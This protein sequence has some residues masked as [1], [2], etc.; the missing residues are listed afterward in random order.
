MTK[1]HERTD[2]FAVCQNSKSIKKHKHLLAKLLLP[3]AG[4][5]SLVWFLIRVIPKPSRALYPCQRVAA[6]LASGFVA[7]LIGLLSSIAFIRKARRYRS[8]LSFLTAGLCFAAAVGSIWWS[9]SMTGK[10]VSA[11]TF[12]P[13][14][15]PNSPIGTAR[16][17]YPGRV[18]WVHDANATSW[19][20]STG[21]WSD[22]TN[23]D[24]AVVNTMLSKA[25]RW[26]TGETSD[27]NSWQEI[28][29][30]FNERHGKGRVGYQSG[31]KIAIKINMAVCADNHANPANAAYNSPQF[32]EALLKQL[33]N[34][35]GVRP[36]DITVYDA[37][38]YIPS[39]I[40]DR[41]STGQLAG[42]KFVDK[43]GGD[44]RIQ[45]Q[46]DLN[47]IVYHANPGVPPRWLPTCV[48]EANYVINLAHL[49]AHFLPGVTLCAKNFFG[50]TWVHSDSNFPPGDWRGLEG[51]WPGYNIHKF[52]NA[53][54]TT[55]PT[56][57]SSFEFPARPMGS[58]NPLV[59]LMGHKNLGNK[60]V[61]FMIDGLYAGKDASTLSPK[62]QM[63]PFNND[64]TSSVFASQDGVAIDSVALDFLR[65]ES[66]ITWV[67]DSNN[68]STADDYLHEAALANDPCSGTVYNPD[69]T[70]RLT[71]LG[72]HEHWN[73]SSEK[74][75]SR[76][77]GTGCGIELI[78][79]P[80]A[81]LT[82]DDLDRDGKVDL[83][84][85]L[86]LTD[87]WLQHVQPLCGGDL[88]YDGFV[89]LYDFAILSEGWRP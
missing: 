52:I 84:D 86:A 30:Y 73:N 53:Y 20:G 14:D 71:S 69:G 50:S 89:N 8:Q 54:D 36:A 2:K 82:L 77:L 68:Y 72:I 67:A 48:T 16:G 45:A 11:G 17:I 15:P 10:S 27:A 4:I 39:T 13:S 28:F 34:N 1:L 85:L 22:N 51:F 31:E 44:G 75:Y 80:P 42:V 76:N 49:K 61:L 37:S 79:A 7:W 56:N 63:S 59:E 26:L 25:I 65:C 55:P 87:D 6:P 81:E 47:A 33:V 12:T 57:P 3:A 70:G 58:Y 9:A 66:V 19:D 41:C 60:T 88:N 29:R 38:R 23:T 83:F 74:Q 40:Y 21:Y 64:W 78:S 24:Q 5:I 18:V 35:A 32:I 43:A 62:W 46:P